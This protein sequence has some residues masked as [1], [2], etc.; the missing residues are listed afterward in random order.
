MAP[1]VCTLVLSSLNRG[2]FG[3]VS[4]NTIIAPRVCTLVLSSP[5]RDAF[6]I[7]SHSTIIAPRVCTLV[8]FIVAEMVTTSV[9]VLATAT[10]L[11]LQLTVCCG[12]T[13]VPSLFQGDTCRVSPDN[14]WQLQDI[15]SSNRHIILNG[16][17][18]NV[19]GNTGSIVIES[20]SNLTIS[21]RE[22]GSLIQCSPNS[23]FGLHLNNATNVTLTEI[24]IR[25]CGFFLNQAFRF[26]CYECNTSILIEASRDVNLS[27]VHIKHSPGF[28]MTVIDYSVKERSQVPFFFTDNVNPHLTLID[29]TLSHSRGWA[30]MLIEGYTSVLIERT[31][32][33]NSENALDSIYADIMIKNVDVINC[34]YSYLLCIRA[35]VRG[36]LTM[37][38]SSLRIS[39]Q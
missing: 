12:A 30:N 2:A 13:T 38:N 24:T 33:T 28:A 32:I 10:L 11:I 15:I 37:N 7:V 22:S 35:M 17:E 29:C 16:G 18:F 27:G 26:N 25:N 8:L 5:N 1:K 23:T 9:A 20:V 6:G 36:A 39:D 19:N 3:R 34:T 21:G 31:V 4:Y 14:F